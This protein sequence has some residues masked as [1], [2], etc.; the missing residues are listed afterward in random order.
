MHA[1]SMMLSAYYADDQK[2]I[3]TAA[4]VD[5]TNAAQVCVGLCPHPLANRNTA[6]LATT[7][8]GLYF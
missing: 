4:K 6:Q 3:D 7:M 5:T 8:P 2:L 1:A